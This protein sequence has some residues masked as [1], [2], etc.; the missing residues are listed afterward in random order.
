MRQL[1]FIHFFF[2]LFA[3]GIP[4]NIISAEVDERFQKI[5]DQGNTVDDGAST[6]A[7]VL[8]TKTGLYWE[9]KTVDESIHSN[10]AKYTYANAG[11]FLDNLNKS[12]FG[13]YSDWRLPTED[14]I[15]EIKQKKKGNEAYT[16]FNYFPNTM[17]SKY[18]AHGWC[19]SKS[20]F[21][22]S[23]VKFGKQRVKGGKYV[24][25]VRGKPLE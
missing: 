21:Q 23:S 4:A 14:E 20:A 24:R 6:W 7:I 18:L 12:N 5:D 11:I 13:G 19:G 15:F 1:V 3:I 10:S 17:P 22:E 16:N 2:I 9:V 8:D 25:A